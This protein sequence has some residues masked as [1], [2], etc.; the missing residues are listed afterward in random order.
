MNEER[1]VHE[2]SG[3]L[4]DYLETVYHLVKKYRFARVRDIADDRGVKAAS[5]TP[6]LKRLS[7]LGLVEYEKREYVLLTAEGE[8]QALRVVARHQVLLRF[9]RDFLQM[10]DATAEKEACA[11]E[12]SLSNEGM[13]RLVRFLEFV[14]LCPA[15]ASD[16]LERFHGCARVQ[17]SVASCPHPCPTTDE[18]LT[19]GGIPTMGLNKIRPGSQCSVV[20]VNASGAVRQRLLDLGLLPG[21]VV[22]VLRAAPGGDP[23]WIVVQGTEMAL[24]RKEAEAVLVTASTGSG[25][26]NG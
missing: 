20:Q 25:A 16:F 11:M 26:R 17:E 10:P 22:Q 23:I 4:E 12:H 2:L 6:A 5:V 15:G 8:R 13:D 24:R 19:P 14:T 9:F 7:D 21:V 18:N 3:S 1:T